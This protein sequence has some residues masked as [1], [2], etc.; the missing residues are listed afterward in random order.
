MSL[1]LIADTET[2]DVDPD[3]QVIEL[4]FHHINE[5][6]NI[7]NSYES[8]VKATKPISPSAAGTHGITDAMLVDCP[9]MA[10]VMHTLK[11]HMG[12]DFQDVFLIA[13]NAQFD[14][15][16]LAGVWNVTRVLCTL[17]AARKYIPE[18][19]D[20]KLQTLKY[21]LNFSA[22]SKAHS[23]LGDVQTVYELLLY[24]LDK[25]GLSLCELQLDVSQ[26][27]LHTT[28]PFGKHKGVRLDRLSYG[29]KQW[30]LGLP[31]LDSDLR[32]SLI[33]RTK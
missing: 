10:E 16:M 13:H 24:L 33:G 3:A 18:A 22:G 26:P 1:I 17:R 25:T 8:R 9:T 2:T 21:L 15:R 5:E 19:P 20:H 12:A 23:A 27:V 29:Y 31:D 7:L 11:E 30:L 32:S 14:Q 4:G 6:L 28:M